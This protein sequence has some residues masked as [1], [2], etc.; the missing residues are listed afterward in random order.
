M[1]CTVS[2]RSRSLPKQ[3][4]PRGL[5]RHQD[6]L[7]DVDERPRRAFLREHA[8]HLEAR[9]RDLDFLAD[10]GRL[11]GAEEI[12]DRR[13]DHG[14]AL[15]CRVVPGRV[16][17][18]VLDRGVLHGGVVGGG[19][20]DRQVC[21]AATQLHLHLLLELRHHRR[22]EAA[23]ALERLRV[24]QRETHPVGARDS[25]REALTGKDAQQVGPQRAD[26]GFDRLLGPASQRDHGDQRPNADDDAERGETG[27]KQVRP[28]RLQCRRDGFA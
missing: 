1:I 22:K 14:V 28:D 18:A 27:A 5:Q 6:L 24:I 8:D 20:D 23:V 10:D 2:A 12:G 9:A 7:V 15:A 11:V 13:A 3:P 25:P 19:A 16:H 4:V 21:V 26:T 17:P